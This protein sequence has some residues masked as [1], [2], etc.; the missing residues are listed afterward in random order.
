MK[1]QIRDILLRDWDPVGIKDISEAQDEYDIYIAEVEALLL[2]HASAEEISKYLV[3]IEKARMGFSEP[4][5]ER[6]LK[7]AN[8]LVMLMPPTTNHDQASS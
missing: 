4:H 7:A 1:K 5:N 3:W 6:I 2:K 8:N